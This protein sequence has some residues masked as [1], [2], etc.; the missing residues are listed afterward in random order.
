MEHRTGRHVDDRPPV[1]LRKLT[2][3]QLEVDDGRDVVTV[4]H[5]RGRKRR[6]LQRWVLVGDE[7]VLARWLG[8]GLSLGGLVLVDDQPRPSDLQ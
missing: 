5:D 1:Q 4:L 3:H 6:E 7:L 8:F 2:G